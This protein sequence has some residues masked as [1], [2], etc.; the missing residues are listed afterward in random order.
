MKLT[1]NGETIEYNGNPT[2]AAL[3]KERG[4][5]GKVAVAVNQE[6]VPKSTHEEHELTEGDDIEIVAPMQGG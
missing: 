5:E 2:L 3:I 4:H 1:V 6:F